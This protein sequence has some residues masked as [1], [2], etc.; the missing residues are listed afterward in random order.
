MAYNWW[1]EDGLLE[2]SE[3]TEGQTKLL[4]AIGKKSG[5]YNCF[6]LGDLLSVCL[7]CLYVKETATMRPGLG[8]MNLRFIVGTIELPN[9]KFLAVTDNR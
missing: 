3:T 2:Q 5:T 7:D 1:I 6:F 9:P 8:S 4:K